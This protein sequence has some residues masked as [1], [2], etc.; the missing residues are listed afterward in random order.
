MAEQPVL[1]VLSIVSYPFLPAQTGGQKGIALF[2]KYF[3]RQVEL[4]CITPKSNQNQLAGYITV[5]LFGQSKF[6]YINILN[7]F[8]IR[9]YLKAQNIDYVVLEHPYF[10]WLGLMLKYFCRV[11]LVVHSHNIESI[12]WKNL[13]KWWWKILFG[14]EKLTHKNADINFFITDEDKEY[15][16]KEFL[17]QRGKCITVTYG[18]EIRSKPFPEEVEKA[19]KFLVDKYGIGRDEMVILFNGAFNYAPNLKALECVCNEINP[20]LLKENNLKYKILICGK[21]I[22][23]DWGVTRNFTNI[24]FAGF[25][26]DISIYLKGAALF[27][28][29]ITDGGGIK[30]KL[31]EALAYNLKCIS[32]RSGAIGIPEQITGEKLFVAEDGDVSEFAR[33]VM[34]AAQKPESDIPDVF[35]E[36][37]YW[38]NI[39]NRCASMLRQSIK[40][41]L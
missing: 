11:R 7:F 21:H 15:A 5:P 3:S 34:N 12:R 28:N 29:P 8:F 37:F 25:V 23:P 10:G 27:L 31:V 38:E 17:L 39:V 13:G 4:H 35:F 14:Y 19:R 41:K 20:I 22:P 36:R 1:K 24:I 32:F 16:I 33:L 30:T 40:T 26:D 9:K 6:R 18:T 2:N